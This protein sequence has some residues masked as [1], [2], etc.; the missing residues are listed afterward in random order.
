MAREILG[1]YLRAVDR[2]FRQ[3]ANEIDG[4]ID[5]TELDVQAGIARKVGTLAEGVGASV[6]KAQGR[7]L[8]RL[9][10][11]SFE[12]QA[13]LGAIRA[14]RDR[15]IR[16]MED[17]GRFYAK[18]VRKIFETPGIFGLRV[19]EI[20]KLIQ[21]R[22]G[23]WESRA[24]L[25]ARDQVLKLHGEINEERQTKAGIESYTWSTSRDSRVRPEHAAMEGKTVAWSNPPEFGHP[26]DDY[27]CRCVGVPIL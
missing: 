9:L 17:A 7:V 10:G 1:E 15:N 14:F 4:T 3:D 11:V 23:V 8:G 24:E 2:F 16:L 26:G 19:E 18:D 22:A 25:I 5:L 27:M 6:A 20:R 21:D 12:D 13:P